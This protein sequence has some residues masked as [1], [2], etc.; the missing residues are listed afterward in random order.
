LLKWGCAGG[1]I[2]S[3]YVPRE[4]RRAWK[5]GKA[6]TV[7][8]VTGFAAVMYWAGVVWGR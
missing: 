3:V 4:R 6:L 1:K 5:P 2:E 7:L 8:V